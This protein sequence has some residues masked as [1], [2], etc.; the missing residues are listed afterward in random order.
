MGKMKYGLFIRGQYSADDDMTV[1]FDELMDQARLAEKL[2]FSSVL[3]GQHY[4][5][6]PLQELQQIPFLARV[7][8]ECPSLS[9]ITGIILLSLHKPL[10]I[11][12]Q[13]ATLDIMSKGRLIFGAGLGYRDVELKAFG[14]NMSERASRFE[15]NLDAIVRLWTD[16]PVSMKG[17]HF[18]LVDA[19][20]S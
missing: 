6:Y 10:D 9:L 4:A 14:T 18:E 20:P 13:L 8:A 7:M 3:K 12:E 17:S 1:R 2:G 11:A 15:E 19:T 16:A 5:G